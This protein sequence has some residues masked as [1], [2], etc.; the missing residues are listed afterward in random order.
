MQ[1]VYESP[2]F[3]EGHMLFLTMMSLKSYFFFQFSSLL[4]PLQPFF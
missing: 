3:N 2:R 1:L 4:E